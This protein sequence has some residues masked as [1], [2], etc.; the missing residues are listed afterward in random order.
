MFGYK[1][2][3][4][5]N[6]KF[7]FNPLGN[8]FLK[9]I[10]DKNKISKIFF[11]ML[12]GVQFPNSL[13]TDPIFQIYPFRLIFKLLHDERLENK[14]FAFEVAYHVV[15]VKSI[16]KEN[17]EELVKSILEIRKLSNEDLEKNFKEEEHVLVNAT[18]EWD[19]YVSKFLV[20]AG[21]L[22]KEEGE[23]IC[24]LNQGEN[25]TRKLTK[26]VVTLNKNVESLY[27]KL[28]QSYPVTE[29]PFLLN[30][31]EQ[32]S[33][34]VTKDIHNFFPEELLE[35]IGE[36][37]D[38]IKLELLNLPKLI[39]KYAENHDGKEWDLFEDVL[40]DGFNSFYNVE[41]RG[42]GGAGKTD[43]ECL[44]ITKKIKFAVDGKSTKAKLSSLNAGRLSHHRKKIGALY[45]IVV[46][47]RYVPSVKFDIKESDTVKI[48]VLVLCPIYYI[49]PC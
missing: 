47:P 6:D 21:I 1:D 11:T 49:H 32:L 38:K 20:G 14:L 22:E 2:K 13:G 36:K 5:G 48:L 9:N 44:Y 24:T 26:N 18:Y 35:E 46:T 10:K 39:E 8:L 23:V 16:N 27:V 17:Y 3:V 28:E 37:K 33:I 45:T 41:A 19:Y 12:W 29:K 31:P 7:M 4:D 40:V 15:F 25:T 43:V 42:L 30:D 34:N